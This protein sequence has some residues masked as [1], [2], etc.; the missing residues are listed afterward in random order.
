[1]KNPNPVLES[2]TRLRIGPFTVRVWRTEARFKDVDN[3]DLLEWSV[4]L[5][6]IFV[7]RCGAPTAEELV[8]AACAFPRVSAAEVLDELGCG[9]ILYP[10]WR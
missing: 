3:A 1:M 2:M 8:R 9:L 4:K 10:D 7:H 6:N 5:N